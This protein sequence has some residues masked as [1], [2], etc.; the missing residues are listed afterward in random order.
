M[1]APTVWP[2]LTIAIYTEP[3]LTRIDNSIILQCDAIEFYSDE[4][5]P[6]EAVYKKYYTP[7]GFTRLTSIAGRWHIENP[8]GSFSN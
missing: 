3:P 7:Y 4:I 5:K 2:G 8:R 1:P 6:Y